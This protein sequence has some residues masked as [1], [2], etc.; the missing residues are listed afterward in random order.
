MYIP[1]DRAD[2]NRSLATPFVAEGAGYQSSNPGAASH[3]GG[4]STLGSGAWT[5]AVRFVVEARPIWAL[6]E[7]TEICIGRYDGGHGRNI[8]SKET[9]TNHCNSSDKVD[10]ACVPH[11]D[12]L[13][14]KD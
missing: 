6:I 8:K 12:R 1:K 5:R 3:G 13:I 4:Y 14:V 7:V 10:I 11:C 9:T 2:L